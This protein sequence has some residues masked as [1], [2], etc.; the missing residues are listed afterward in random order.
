MC[1]LPLEEST[2]PIPLSPGPCT[3]SPEATNSGCPSMSQPSHFRGLSQ[4]ESWALKTFTHSELM[5]QQTDL[6]LF[7]CIGSWHSV[8]SM[9]AQLIDVSWPP[10]LQYSLPSRSTSWH[11]RAFQRPRA[12][13][14]PCQMT[15]KTYAFLLL[16]LP[17][18]IT[19]GPSISSS[20]RRHFAR[21]LTILALFTHVTLPTLQQ[22]VTIWGNKANSSHIINN[23]A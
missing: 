14:L 20:F 5:W 21:Q 19:L 13:R 3:C 7:C 17:L 9:S 23:K 1:C 4:S 2:C 16:A 22:L 11:S 8:K 15:N 10:S 6:G 12:C 18:G